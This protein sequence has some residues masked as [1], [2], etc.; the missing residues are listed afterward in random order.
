MPNNGSIGST[1]RLKN[2]LFNKAILGGRLV[3][4]HNEPKIRDVS[5]EKNG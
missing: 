3:A 2:A 5:A 4:H 1:E